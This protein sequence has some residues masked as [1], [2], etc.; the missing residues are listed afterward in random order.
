MTSETPKVNE[1][2]EGVRMKKNFMDEL[3]RCLNDGSINQNSS[4]HVKYDDNIVTAITS[5]LNK[6]QQTYQPW[7]ASTPNLSPSQLSKPVASSNCE[8]IAAIKAKSESLQACDVIVC[9]TS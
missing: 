5:S 2:G 4:S 9:M 3:D 7:A 8:Q 1:E 6:L